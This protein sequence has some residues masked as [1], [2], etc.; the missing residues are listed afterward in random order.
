M[1]KIDWLPPTGPFRV[2]EDGAD[3][4]GRDEPVGTVELLVVHQGVLRRGE[5]GGQNHG[6]LELPGVTARDVLSCIS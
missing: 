5:D 2:F 3:E 1:A 4:A 6:W